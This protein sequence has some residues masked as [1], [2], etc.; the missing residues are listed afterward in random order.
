M[1][2]YACTDTIHTNKSPNQ[3]THQKMQVLGR[4]LRRRHH[5]Q[6]Q[7]ALLEATKAACLPQRL[8]WEGESLALEDRFKQELAMLRGYVHVLVACVCVCTPLPALIAAELDLPL[9]TYTYTQG[10]G[11]RPRAAGQQPPQAGGGEAGRAGRA[12]RVVQPPAGRF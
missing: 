12:G 6:R 5:A 3:T 7:K 4:F 8:E 9:P 2:V 10:G 1:Y 11:R